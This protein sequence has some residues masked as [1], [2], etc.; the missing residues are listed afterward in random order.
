MYSIFFGTKAAK[1][2]LPILKECWFD[3]ANIPTLYAKISRRC[4]R[5]ESRSP[6]G[7]GSGS[8]IN[9]FGSTTLEIRDSG[10]SAERY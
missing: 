5:Q 7:S 1:Q 8:E 2:K 10:K 3:I 9:S 6:E 4:H